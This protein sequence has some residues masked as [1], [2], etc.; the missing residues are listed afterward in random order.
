M[1]ELKY[2]SCKVYTELK[3]HSST[4]NFIISHVGFEKWIITWTCQREQCIRSSVSMT[5]GIW[6]GKTYM[7]SVGRNYTKLTPSSFLSTNTDHLLRHCDWIFQAVIETKL[8][9]ATKRKVS[10]G[11][12]VG[13][14][15][16][17]CACVRACLSLQLREEVI[18]GCVILLP[19]IFFCR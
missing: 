15:G 8:S 19:N 13:M 6:E 16:C 2:F 9:S 11:G 17:G 4:I 14:H 10:D 1:K 5:Y 3:R 18:L 12:W 7:Y